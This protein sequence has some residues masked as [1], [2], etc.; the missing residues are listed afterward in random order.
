M[1]CLDHADSEM[2]RY[3]HFQ[4]CDDATYTLVALENLE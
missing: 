4:V 3:P 1:I 2:Y